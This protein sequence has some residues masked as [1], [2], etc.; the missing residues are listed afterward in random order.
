MSDSLVSV[1]RPAMVALLCCSLAGPATAGAASFRA[2]AQPPA[3]VP[4]DGDS[5]SDP[6]VALARKAALAWLALVDAG[7]FE[8][9]WD[10]AA[11]S[12]QKAQKKEAWAQGLGSARPTMGALVKRTY[13]NHQIRTALPK[14]PPDKY[15]TIRFKSVFA[16]HQDGSE[17]V[18]LVKDG[19]RGFRMMSYFLK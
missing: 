15:V 8:A 5:S 12:F 9:T 7:K 16:N 11:R 6:D 14:L 18:T 2:G 4:S 3:T 10:E 13:L 17:S 19:D 1:V